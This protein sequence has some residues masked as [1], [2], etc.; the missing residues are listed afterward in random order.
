[1]FVGERWRT[2]HH[3]N[4][5]SLPLEKVCSV[6]TFFWV[7]VQRCVQ[8]IRSA[9]YRRYVERDIVKWRALAS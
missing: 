5:L 8:T 3:G 4:A 6:S 2:E 1:M 9:S 7:I